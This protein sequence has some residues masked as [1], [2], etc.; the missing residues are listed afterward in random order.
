MDKDKSK[1]GSFSGDQKNVVVTHHQKHLQGRK[2]DTPDE[3]P[4]QAITPKIPTEVVSNPVDPGVNPARMIKTKPIRKT[5]QSPPAQAGREAPMQTSSTRHT[6][7]PLAAT[8]TQSVEGAPGQEAVSAPVGARATATGARSYSGQDG[9]W[10]VGVA[11]FLSILSLT[12]AG[13][14]GVW[15]WQTDRRISTIDGLVAHDQSKVTELVNQAQTALANLTQLQEDNQAQ[16]NALKRLKSE[17]ELAQSQLVRY[18]GQKEWVLQEAQ[19]LIQNADIQ[20]TLNQDVKTAQKQLEAADKKIKDLANPS[21]NAVRDAIATDIMLLRN[22]VQI[23]KHDMWSKLTALEAQFYQLKFKPIVE[24]ALAS[25]DEAKTDDAASASQELSLGA[26]FK[27]HA[28]Y[29]WQEFKSLIRVSRYDQDVM[30]PVLTSLEQA[31]LLR[32]LELILEEAKWGVLKSDSIVYH[33]S[34]G[35]MTVLIQQFF[36]ESLPRTHLLKDIENLAAVSLLEKMPEISNS[37]IAVK[38]ALQTAQFKDLQQEH[39]S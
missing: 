28:N 9:G 18:S 26:S 12:V 27:Q 2:P 10:L 33:Q 36:E 29:A 24:E 8:S 39:A 11:C 30:Q 20:L 32:S 21:L 31:Q 13:G 4:T 38:Q 15:G 34:L 7:G 16:Q 1:K 19:F 5:T 17:I 35:K 6:D 23:D 25:S 22:T 37:L 3:E 14:L